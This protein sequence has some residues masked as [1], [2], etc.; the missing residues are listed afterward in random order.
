MSNKHKTSILL[1]GPMGVGKT[2]ISE[3]LAKL[4]EL[5]LVDVDDL[6]K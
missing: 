5:P 3:A 1:I 2:T 4:Y 6:R